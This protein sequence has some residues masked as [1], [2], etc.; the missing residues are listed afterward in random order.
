M[1]DSEAHGGLNPSAGGARAASGLKFQAEVF[2]WWAAHAVS[3][4]APG[5]GLDPQVRVEAV[6]CETGFP[7]DDVGVAL[8][9]GGFILV[10]AK[11]GMRRLDPRAQDLRKAVDQVV[12]AMS[13]G[14]HAGVAIRSVDVA[15]QLEYAGPQVSIGRAGSS[16]VSPCSCQGLPGRELADECI[17]DVSPGAVVAGSGDGV[18]DAGGG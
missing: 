18:R 12:S 3:G 7:V 14:L 5:L 9:D 16:R 13:G 17:E 1:N 11:G 10:Q 4:T 15:I 2:A 8:S 6:G